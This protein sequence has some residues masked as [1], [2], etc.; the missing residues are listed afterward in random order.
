MYIIKTSVASNKYRYFGRKAS[1]LLEE[2]RELTKSDGK[3]SL[4]IFGVLLCIHTTCLFVI[5]VAR[6]GFIYSDIQRKAFV[7]AF[8]PFKDSNSTESYIFVALFLLFLPPTEYFSAMYYNFL[9]LLIYQRYKLLTTE[10]KKTIRQRNIQ[11]NEIEQLRKEYTLIR[12]TVYKFTSIFSFYLSFNLGS[13]MLM[14]CALIYLAMTKFILSYIIYITTLNVLL[15]MM[16]FTS[17]LL[18]SEVSETD[19]LILAR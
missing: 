17:S 19:L 15:F 6:A 1:N 4:K 16:L 10:L 14:I 8:Y 18:Y 3:S 2:I 9:C 7:S 5:S 12:K 11:N 13:W